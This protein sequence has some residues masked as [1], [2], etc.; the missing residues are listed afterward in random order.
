MHNTKGDVALMNMS[1]ENNFFMILCSIPNKVSS[2]FP[3][4]RYVLSTFLNFGHFSASCS[5]KKVLIKK[6]VSQFGETTSSL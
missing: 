2:P 4:L 5:Y 1:R 6:S 3:Q